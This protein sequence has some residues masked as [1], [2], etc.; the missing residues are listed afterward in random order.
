MTDMATGNVG[1]ATLNRRVKMAGKKHRRKGDRVER[2]IVHLLR[3]HGIEAERVP[4]SGAAGGSFSG[5]VLIAGAYRA[6][7]KARS[8]G[9]GFRML[10]AWLEG[11]DL[12][13]LKR[14]RRPPMVVMDFK[15]CTHLLH[16]ALAE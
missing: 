13:I 15:L 14:D 11:S 7:V 16:S 9:E 12:L 4:L 1:Y 5:D 2:E 3:S 10:E 6:E 8:N